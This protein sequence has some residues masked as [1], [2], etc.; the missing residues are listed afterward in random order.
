MNL[1]K[2]DSLVVTIVDNE[3][4]LNSIDKKITEAQKLVKQYCH[5][6]NLVDDLLNMRKD[7]TKNEEQK[8]HDK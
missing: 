5:N 3:I 8:D 6:N 7:E 1:K 4:H 2:G